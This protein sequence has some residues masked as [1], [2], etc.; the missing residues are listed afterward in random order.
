MSDDPS[1]DPNNASL[2]DQKKKKRKRSICERCERPTPAACICE[3][4][5][6]EPLELKHCH[7]L[8]LQ[9]PHESRRKNRSLPLIELCLSQ[10]SISVSVARRFGDAIDS[11]IMDRLNKSR[12]PI[13]L[14]Y[15]DSENGISLQQALQERKS[16]AN[17]TNETESKPVTIVFLDGTWKYA[18][19]MD[20]ANRE[21]KQYPSHMKRIQLMESDLKELTRSKRFDIRTPPSDQHLS[22]AE[23]ISWVVSKVEGNEDIY[24]TLMKPLDFMV[25]RWH[26]FKT[27]K[28]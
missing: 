4:L 27:Q 28:R 9:H 24:Q 26:S 17:E 16:E 10:Q 22:T 11:T 12:N 13:W 21:E 2:S 19:E 20:Q 15:P 1:A 23:C 7:C 8:V 6:S 5:P 3:A 18:K 14:I 25:E